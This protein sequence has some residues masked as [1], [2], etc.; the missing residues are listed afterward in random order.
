M[1]VIDL[2]RRAILTSSLETLEML[3]GCPLAPDAREFI[4]ARAEALREM[5][6]IPSVALVA[7]VSPANNAFVTGTREEH[8]LDIA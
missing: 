7:W 2:F 3:E 8:A 5:S 1:K 6:E 4:T